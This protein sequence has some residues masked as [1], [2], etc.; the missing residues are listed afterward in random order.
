[1]DLIEALS[2]FYAS[3]DG[4]CSPATILF[5]R[6]TL[7]SLGDY[8]GKCDI[9][10]IDTDQ[11]RTWRSTLVNRHT[12]WGKG[13]SHPEQP[14][15]L[16]TYTIHKFVRAARRLFRWL[17]LEN[18]LEV[19]PAKRLELPELPQCVA[20]GISPKKRLRLMDAATNP[21]DVAIIMLLSDTACRRGG[22]AGLRLSDLHLKHRAVLTRE[23]GRGGQHKERWLY[24]KKKTGKAIR[25]WLKVRPAG[26]GDSLFGLTPDG[27]Y[28]LLKRL[29]SKA[30]ISDD[31][32]PHSFRHATI[33][34]WLAAG[35]PLPQASQLAGH[36]SVMVTGDIYGRF[37]ERD[38]RKA[39]RKYS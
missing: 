25:A 4:I 24:F 21:R 2:R 22:L 6:N 34:N 13:S 7:T 14:G 12:R 3:M 26:L 33:R 10:S 38:L 16:S 23:K 31:W 37:N 18:I 35:M 28:Q 5:Y 30:D 17:C 15:Q 1:M 19:D 9:Q 32:N 27:V 36:S 11:L 39:H 20:K 8:F 29:A